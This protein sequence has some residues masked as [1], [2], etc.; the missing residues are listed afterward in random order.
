MRYA[1]I[2]FLL[3]GSFGVS[4]Q[5][6]LWEISGNGLKKPSYLYGT[7]HVTDPRVFQLTEPAV[8]AFTKADI[9]ALELQLDGTD[10]V[11]MF[12]YLFIPED[13]AGLRERLPEAQYTFLEEVM[14]TQLGTPLA[15]M[16]RFMPIFLGVMLEEAPAF[17]PALGSG[18]LPL[19][20]FLALVGEQQGKRVV[21]L[22]SIEEQ[23]GIFTSFTLAEQDS[24]LVQAARVITFHS[25]SIVAAFQQMID[26][27]VRGDLDALM[28]E[29][30]G[31]AFVEELKDELLTQRNRRMVARLLPLMQN[32]QQVF[33]GVGA[34][35]LLGKDGLVELLQTKGYTVVPIQ[36]SYNPKKR[37]QLKNPD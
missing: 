16:D 15:F 31:D 1:I 34:A 21:G 33:V 32:K 11:A 27:Y 2:T 4:G 20:A 37:L 17:A 5:S 7:M 12:D 22:E 24:Y 23:A 28:A 19:D 25:D 26:A 35:H 36:G 6:L 9:L 13:S 10:M 3:A 18:E 29:L 14:K 30:A 8:K